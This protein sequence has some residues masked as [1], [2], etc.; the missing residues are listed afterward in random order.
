MLCHD[1]QY[2][3]T[4]ATQHHS[5][6]M[7]TSSRTFSNTAHPGINRSTIHI[8]TAIKSSVLRVLMIEGRH[9]GEKKK[10]GGRSVEEGQTVA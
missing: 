9:H 1:A 10:A 2:P 3:H 5:L 6:Q 7:Q 8:R 4:D